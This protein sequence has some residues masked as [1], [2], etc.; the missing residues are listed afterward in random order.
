MDE[1]ARTGVAVI[2]TKNG[3]PVAELAPHRPPGRNARGILKGELF[4]VGDI[5]API[6]VE[7]DALK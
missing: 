2:I 4:V 7:W 5:I 3:K 1:V 6:E